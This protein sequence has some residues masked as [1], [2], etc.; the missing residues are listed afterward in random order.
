[1]VFPNHT[2]LLFVN[3]DLAL[4]SQTINAMCGSASLEEA[5]GYKDVAQQF[6]VSGNVIVRLRT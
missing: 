5:Y 2:D 3:W 4:G 6:S 1:M